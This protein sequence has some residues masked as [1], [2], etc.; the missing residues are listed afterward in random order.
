MCSNFFK[1]FR[2]R[3]G[4]VHAEQGIDM[5]ASDNG[6][7]MQ[8]QQGIMGSSA[9]LQGGIAQ[10]TLVHAA[11]VN[12]DKSALSKL[13][14]NSHDDI[15][16]GDQFGRTP[17]MLTV[18]ADRLECA[19]LLIKHGANINSIDSVGRTA[20]HWAAYK[21]NLRFCKLLLAKGA[22]WRIKDREGQSALHLATRHDNTKCLM[23]LI[24]QLEPGEQDEQDNAKRTALHWSSSYGNEEA[25]KLLIKHN[26]NIGIPDVDGKTPLHWAASAGHDTSAVNTVQ[27]IL[28]TE[29]SVITWQDY[30][31]RTALH[32]AV[33]QG[34]E[35]IAKQLI[36]FQTSLVKCNVSVL[37]NMFRTPLHWA[38]VLGHTHIVDLLLD[39][40][41]NVTS[42][43]ANG[44]TPLHYAAQNNHA[45][46]VAAFLSRD[47]I[48]DEPDLEGR[49]ALMWAAGKGA[50]AVIVRMVDISQPDINA[51]DKTGATALHAAAMC[52][53]PSTIQ[54]LL[55]LDA[56]VNML[57]QSKHTPLFRAAEMG[58]TL[59]AKALVQGG[60]HVDI[61]DQEGRSPLHWAALG[62]HTCICAILVG[63]GIDPN[64]QDFN[65]RTPLQCASYGGFTNSISLLLEKGADPNS[66][67]IEGMTAL[68]W[69]CSSG[70]LDAAKLLLDHCAFPNHIEYTEDRFTPLDYALLNEHHHIAQYMIEQGALSITGIRDIAAIR[71]QAYF[72]GYRVRKTFVER[73]K[74]LMKHE[75]LRK[76]A[77]KKRVEMTKKIETKETLKA[78]TGNCDAQTGQL[79]SDQIEK[80]G[81][82]EEVSSELR[83]EQ[84]NC[85]LETELEL[86][87]PK[88]R[89]WETDI[90]TAG[91]ASNE[92]IDIK[93]EDGSL[94][95][96]VR[97]ENQSSDRT[98]SDRGRHNLD[99]LNVRESQTRKGSEHKNDLVKEQETASVLYLQSSEGA[100]IMAR[101]Q[102]RTENNISLVNNHTDVR[103]GTANANSNNS[104]SNP[105]IVSG[106]DKRTEHGKFEERRHL[107]GQDRCTHTGGNTVTHQLSTEDRQQVVERERRRLTVW[108][109]E[110]DSAITIQRAWKNFKQHQ[111]HRNVSHYLDFSNTKQW[112][113]RRKVPMSHHR[114]DPRS[115]EAGDHHLSAAHTIKQP[116]RGYNLNKLQS[117]SKAGSISQPRLNALK[118]AVL[119]N[120]TYGNKQMASEPQHSSSFV[121]RARPHYQRYIPSPAALSF[122]FAM[123]QYRPM[124][125][126]IRTPASLEM[127]N[128]RTKQDTNQHNS[129]LYTGPQRADCEQSPKN[130]RSFYYNHCS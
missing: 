78:N 29:P 75:Q 18:L 43:D 52:G 35:T 59:V 115:D 42:S 84:T 104:N 27:L 66:Q 82:T 8:Q 56:N 6:P 127:L 76:D 44:A 33:A 2:M 87:Q 94:R 77:A 57:D 88:K 20:F 47:G 46:T 61:I 97:D 17:L 53:H 45:D 80:S 9:S 114:I 60:A 34:N 113:N 107:G 65:G 7:T 121:S 98:T 129:S 12:G 70:Y 39:A 40:G 63:E 25:V 50:D 101:N 81:K 3:S 22:N 11:A 36:N 110:S 105:D 62:G 67:D 16:A 32:L 31:G 68:H 99:K 85:E 79:N 89:C 125:R 38:A 4:R 92:D 119:M 95:S 100:K 83:L 118:H 10:S 49:T 1:C 128:H 26:S 55:E 112:A 24:K 103:A 69:C 116:W 108:R 51:T 74:L 13:L 71:I 72:R 126:N 102:E 120:K 91:K 124:V 123:D 93:G 117:A 73:K 96:E 30:E 37:D 86:G 48:T 5:P 90:Q 111:L 64:I 19:E 54:V 41:A 58:H 15:N 23:L 109:R 28:E 122:N 130:A 106:S 21:G 14:N